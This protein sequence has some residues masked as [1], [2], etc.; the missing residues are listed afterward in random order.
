MRIY[1]RPGFPNPTRIR[2][3]LAEKQLGS[4]RSSLSR[5][6]LSGP[7]TRAPRSCKR[8]R[9]AS[10]PR[11]L[12]STTGPSFSESTAITEYL[13]HLD[14]G[15]PTLTGNDAET[16]AL[17]HMMQR[18]AEAELIVIRSAKY[19]HHATPG[20]GLKPSGLQEPR[21][22]RPRRVGTAARRSRARRDELF[23]QR[24]G[25]AGPYVAGEA[26][27]MVDITV[28]AGLLFADAAGLHPFP[29]HSSRSGR[30]ARASCRVAQRENIAA[31]RRFLL[32]MRAASWPAD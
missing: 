11:C 20:L 3:M 12:N 9:R 21:L 10:C 15:H 26:F 6:T 1:D 16:E 19:F 17:I 18:R 23:Q 14:V 29:A 30:V 4:S 31:A 24:V 28:F 22:E 5:S 7:S 2:I 25:A 13:D 8:T 32:T 27:S